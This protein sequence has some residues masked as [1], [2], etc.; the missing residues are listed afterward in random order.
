MPFEARRGLA[1][2]SSWATLDIL[3]DSGK[4]MKHLSLT[5]WGDP[6]RPQMLG[7]ATPRVL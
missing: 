5:K 3:R 2:A 6:G 4:P 7:Y 1:G